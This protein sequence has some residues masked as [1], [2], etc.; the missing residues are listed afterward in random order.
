ARAWRG[1]HGNGRSSARGPCRARAGPRRARRPPPER[2]GW[3]GNSASCASA[4]KKADR[5]AP[6]RQESI[7]VAARSSF[8]VPTVGFEPTRLAALAP[9]ASVSTNSTTSANIESGACA[10][11][12]YLGAGAGAG[13]GA[14]VEA[15]A[16]AGGGGG[17]PAG[18]PHRGGA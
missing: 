3:A 18:R 9:Q 14:G 10:P 11:A 15:G 13:A 7:I 5:T 12:C 16:A 8:L 1:R 2:S 4:V 6:P 17:R